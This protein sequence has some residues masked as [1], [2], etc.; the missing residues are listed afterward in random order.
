M[1][2][3]IARGAPHTVQ[4]APAPAAQQKRRGFILCPACAHLTLVERFE[5]APYEP[6]ARE[7]VVGGY[8]SITWGPIEALPA[9]ACALL[10]AALRR[11]LAV[12]EKARRDP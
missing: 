9:E 3:R 8:K 4:H 1:S 6:Y 10:A 2:K 12:V 7:Q 11:A 5:H